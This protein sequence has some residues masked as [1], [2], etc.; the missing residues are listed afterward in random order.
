MRNG[1]GGKWRKGRIKCVTGQ[2]WHQKD[3]EEIE[4]IKEEQRE[5]ERESNRNIP[6]AKTINSKRMKGGYESRRGEMQPDEMRCGEFKR[7]RA[8]MLAESSLSPIE[9]TLQALWYV[10]CHTE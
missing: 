3:S 9:Q 6:G 7:R 8:A 10:K 5:N 2:T 4:G 1:N